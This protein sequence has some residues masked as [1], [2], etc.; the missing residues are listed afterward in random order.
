MT[1]TKIW[2]PND[3]ANWG[4]TASF[5]RG[6][7][8]VVK[9]Q[10][11]AK[12][13][14]FVLRS[15]RKPE[16]YL[17]EGK[18]L[19]DI[20]SM[21]P[22]II[23]KAFKGG[24]LSLVFNG[25][26]AIS[27]TDVWYYCRLRS[28]NPDEMTKFPS[29]V[30]VGGVFTNTRSQKEEIKEMCIDEKTQRFTVTTPIQEIQD[31]LHPTKLFKLHSIPELVHFNYEKLGRTTRRWIDK[32]IANSKLKL[33]RLVYTLHSGLQLLGPTPLEEQ[34]EMTKLGPSATP[35]QQREA[36]NALMPRPVTRWNTL[37]EIV[38]YIRTETEKQEHM[39]IEEKI[40]SFV[41]ELHKLCFDKPENA[42][43]Y[44]ERFSYR[45]F[46][47]FVTSHIDVEKFKDICPKAGSMSFTPTK[48]QAFVEA[49][50]HPFSP[51]RKMMVISRTGSGKTKMMASIANN[52]FMLDNRKL[53][54]IIVLDSNDTRFKFYKELE[55]TNVKGSL[56]D[57]FDPKGAGRE[58]STK[59]FAGD[60]RPTI[61]DDF[62]SALRDANEN[63]STIIITH[64][65]LRLIVDKDQ[66]RNIVFGAEPFFNQQ[67][68]FTLKNTMIIIDEAHLFANRI[69]RNVVKLLPEAENLYLFTATPV[70]TDTFTNGSFDF[71]NQY[72]K[73][74]GLGESQDMAKYIMYYNGGANTLFKQNTLHVAAQKPPEY[75]QPRKATADMAISSRQPFLLYN[76]L[77]KKFW[78]EWEYDPFVKDYQQYSGGVNILR[79]QSDY[80]MALKNIAEF[81]PFITYLEQQRRSRK[82]IMIYSMYDDGVDYYINYLAEQNIRYIVL[83]FDQAQLYAQENDSVKN[84]I[85][86]NSSYQTSGKN[87]TGHLWY[88]NST[89]VKPNNKGLYDDTDLLR[90]I[91][92][93][94]TT[95]KNNR[96]K[97]TDIVVINIMRDVGIDIYGYNHLYILSPPE[98]TDNFIQIIGRINRYCDADPKKE[99]NIYLLMFT[100]MKFDV[101]LVQKL[102]KSIQ[103]YNTYDKF[104]SSQTMMPADNPTSTAFID[105]KSVIL[106]NIV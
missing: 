31:N 21:Y 79:K 13:P 22:N 1:L 28:T 92:N 106:K 51:C 84:S 104:L 88:Y 17:D 74:M 69:Y 33:S 96:K 63:G 77:G 9:F 59:E 86:H 20:D 99:A 41:Q 24:N 68:R 91:N 100:G 98:K 95:V 44:Q 65:D 101:D 47:L 50:L 11:R 75:F 71:L 2:L 37:E 15:T 87:I 97:N 12:E 18:K 7:N 16:T 70:D 48:Y 42:A 56:Y 43:Q 73:W 8:A 39:K 54:K 32:H 40:N 10:I 55:R 53:N 34:A 81:Y 52:F 64:H 82:K 85:Y 89:P 60:I 38:E 62:C 67:Q 93:E 57:V 105:M 4:I 46:F 83:G 6:V 25:R 80:G 58:P 30:N 19:L 45:E 35:D 66:K 49:A 23:D 72:R 26:T 14:F 5:Q 103:I 27:L 76:Q 78:S 94:A 29:F 36:L 90:L 102:V 61:L 3:A